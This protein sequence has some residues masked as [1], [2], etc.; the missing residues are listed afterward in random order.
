MCKRSFQLFSSLLTSASSKSGDTRS[1]ILNLKFSGGRS[2]KKDIATVTRH[3]V[4]L[5]PAKDIVFSVCGA[6]VP[7]PIGPVGNVIDA[8]PMP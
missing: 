8:A 7:L 2:R 1:K 6:D 5:P 3:G 4:I